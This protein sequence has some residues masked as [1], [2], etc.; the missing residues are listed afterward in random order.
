M[1][2]DLNSLTKVFAFS[3][4]AKDVPIDITGREIRVLVKAFVDESLVVAKVKVGFR[5]VIGDEDL[6]MLEWGHG[7]WVDIDIRV[8]LL[9]DDLEAALF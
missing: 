4:F 5:T 6:T 7:A 8:K 3:F 9:G 1:R 2:N